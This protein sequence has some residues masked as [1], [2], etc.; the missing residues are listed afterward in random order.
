MIIERLRLTDFKRHKD[1]DVSFVKGCNLICGPNYAGKSTL[2][3]AMLL[4]LQG[5]RSVPGETR[6][7]VRDGSRG[8]KVE[9]WLSNGYYISRTVNDSRI[10]V[11]NKVIVNSHSAVNEHL[12]ELFGC[13]R[14][15]FGRVHVCQQGEPQQLLNMDGPELHRFIESCTGVGMLDRVVKGASQ[16]SRTAKE[17]TE[18]YEE[19]LEPPEKVQEWEEEVGTLREKISLSA[20][21]IVPVKVDIEVCSKSSERLM[22]LSSKVFKQ[23]KT[24]AIYTSEKEMA[25]GDLEEVKNDRGLLPV[26]KE[27]GSL[28]DDL[29]S[30]KGILQE[31]LGRETRIRIAE[32]VLQGA[33]SA[34]EAAVKVSE[35]LMCLK[36]QATVIMEISLESYDDDI[37]KLEAGIALRS[38][39]LEKLEKAVKEGVCSECLRPFDDKVKP[40][41]GEMQKIRVDLS[42]L[43]LKLEDREALRRGLRVTYDEAKDQQKLVQNAQQHTQS[44]ELEYVTASDSLEAMEKPVGIV[45]LQDLLFLLENEIS[46]TEINNSK[47]DALIAQQDRL[48]KVLGREPVLKPE[49]NS[50][51][52][53]E[54]LQRVTQKQVELTEELGKLTTV[55]ETSK[56]MLENIEDAL[57]LQRERQTLFVK[58]K[59]KET[60]YKSVADIVSKNRVTL[61]NQTWDLITQ[62]TSEFVRASTGG[63][64]EGVVMTSSGIKYLEHGRERS[65]AL[66][67]GSQKTLMG[68]G[69]KLAVSRIAH[70]GFSSML[71]DEISADMSED[72][73]MNCLTVLSNL[74]EQTIVVS[75]RAMDVADHTVTL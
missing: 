69:L 60:L 38:K 33:L 56:Q 34:F 67:S 21:N 8:F 68:V 3:Q 19:I 11:L 23:E 36:E 25:E 41:Y 7:L 40:P 29:A 39:E 16:I 4:A 2:L 6:E 5:N 57:K 32:E 22:E 73:S 17:K 72:I 20:G 27:V 48:E 70:T 42:A 45:A 50:K 1:I 59:T 12:S 28:K 75:H 15:A 30:S 35:G 62:I 26:L 13:D 53:Q 61:M 74:C 66:A 65:V 10:E 49:R 55:L 52:I 44:K 54:E 64:M 37:R 24:Y 18:V 51:D 31:L 14:K 43:R 63:D 47:V 9:L 71:L 58:E 46:K